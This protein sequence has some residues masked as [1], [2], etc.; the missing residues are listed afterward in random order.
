MLKKEIAPCIVVYR[1]EF[2]NKEKTLQVMRDSYYLGRHGGIL[3][4]EL[5]DEEKEGWRV[6]IDA[7]WRSADYCERIAV[8]IADLDKVKNKDV[9]DIPLMKE[10]NDLATD[11]IQDYIKDHISCNVLPPYIHKDHIDDISTNPYWRTKDFSL[12]IMHDYKEGPQPDSEFLNVDTHRLG[13]GWHVDSVTANANPEMKHCI[14]GN[15]YWNDD[16][17][18]GKIVFLYG[19]TV[20]NPGDT[21]N[22]KIIYYKP[23]AGDLVVYPANWPVAHAAGRPTG[24]DRFISSSIVK[25]QYEGW[26]G[27]DLE[28]Y[29]IKEKLDFDDFARMVREENISYVDGATLFNG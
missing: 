22:L 7:N 3:N 2:L 15:L 5:T 4:P 6:S 12:M 11:C 29:I 8:N 20:L 26:M 19:N 13:F 23:R 27:E 25:Y 17:E 18:G 24:S 1:P 9:E 21:D 28:K 10:L 16:Y 14:T